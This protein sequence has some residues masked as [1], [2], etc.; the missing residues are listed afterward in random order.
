MPKLPFSANNWAIEV[1]KTRQSEFNMADDTP[2]WMERGVA[3]H[4]SR[5]LCPLNSNLLKKEKNQY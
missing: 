4:V 5:R 1:S 2:S 3:S